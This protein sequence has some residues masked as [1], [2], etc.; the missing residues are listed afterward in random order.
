MKS[1]DNIFCGECGTVLQ[2]DERCSLCTPDSFFYES[3]VN[4]NQDLRPW[5]AS[6]TE[7]LVDKKKQLIAQIIALEQKNRL[8]EIPLLIELML[9]LTVIIDQEQ[10]QWNEYKNRI[11]VRLE[12]ANVL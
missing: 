12:E 6:L 4:M 10:Q 8:A 3:S 11:T 1:P 5:I 9:E 7:L 2:Y